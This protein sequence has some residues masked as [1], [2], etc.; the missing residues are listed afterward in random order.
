MPIKP[1][2]SGHTP[3]VHPIQSRRYEVAR[4][5]WPPMKPSEESP[6]RKGWTDDLPGDRSGRGALGKHFTR[7]LILGSREAVADWIAVLHAQ[8]QLPQR[9]KLVGRGI[10]G[11]FN[12]PFTACSRQ[13]HVALPSRPPHPDLIPR[14]IGEMRLQ[15][16]LL[17]SRR[18]QCFTHS[19]QITQRPQLR[20]RPCRDASAR[21]PS[22][23]RVGKQTASS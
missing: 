14:K 9:R 18:P 3:C 16:G 23:R 10:G 7:A 11:P 6:L 8:G 1:D 17:S 5:I 4:Y 22:V 13:P 19:R 21:I 2:R 12:H 15:L 20:N